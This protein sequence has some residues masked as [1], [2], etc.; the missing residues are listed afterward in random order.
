MATIK[1]LY[2]TSNQSITCTLTSLANGSSRQA[3][4]ID[5]S[6][7]LY[8][9][10]LVFAQ[11][12]SGASST[13]STGTAVF[14]AAGSVDGG[15]TYTDNA[16]GPDGTYTPVSP[17]NLKVLGVGNMVA[18]STIYYMGPFS[19]ANAFGGTLPQKFNLVVT[20]SSGGT[21]DGTT[22]TLY[23]QGVQLQSI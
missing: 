22:A 14:Y 6:S 23:Y 17:P 1:P 19:L 5:N 16:V 3:T 15:T 21:F 9:D 7:N 20:N 2:G 8:D 13:S 10:V 12:K 4:A 11:I 18:N